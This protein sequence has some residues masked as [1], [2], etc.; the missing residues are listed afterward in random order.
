MN[1]AIRILLIVVLL[2][3]V[4][5]PGLAQGLYWKSMTTIMS[6][7]MTNEYYYMPKMYKMVSDE[8]EIGIFRIDKKVFY[9]IDPAKHEYSEITFEEMDKMLQKAVDKLK[10][11]SDEMKEQLKNL[12]EEQRKQMEKMLGGGGAEAVAVR[13]T[14]E[15]N[16]IAGYACTKF[17]IQ[18]GENE[19]ATIWAT[20]ALREFE[21]MGKDYEEFSKRMMG[22]NPRLGALAEGMMKV[23]GF[24]METEIGKEMK[25]TVIKVEKRNVGAS[26]FAVPAGYK[27][28][29]SKIEKGLEG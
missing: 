16:T 22:L 11:M 29:K 4:L 21:A 6:K 12:P 3:C 13:N 1:S 24:P 28:V 27:K 10:A 2:L 9:E 5:I 20:A 14:G 8:G 17:V 7:E 25:T 19:V 15:R 23:K 18:Q 26:E